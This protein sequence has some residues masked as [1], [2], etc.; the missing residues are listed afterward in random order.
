[1]HILQLKTGKID[2]LP[3]SG[4]LFAPQWSP[5]GKYATA[6]S[7]KDQR[8]MLFDFARRHGVRWLRDGAWCAGAADS[9]WVYYLRYGPRPAV[10]RVSVP[11]RQIEQVA[12]LEGIRLSGR[13]AG[14]EFRLT[15]DGEP[16]ITR[17]VGTQEIYS[18][19]WRPR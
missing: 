16:I 19:D 9:R 3:D 10:M 17:A 11:D 13:L 1:M 4:G 18:M 7:L 5:D 2:T 12:S 6:L 8:I 15:P 14:L